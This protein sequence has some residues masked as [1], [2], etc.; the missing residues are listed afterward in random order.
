MGLA[1]EDVENGREEGGDDHYGY[2]GV[3]H[4]QKRETEAVGVATEE[5]AYAAG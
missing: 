5:V 2:S 1:E 3:V 4:A